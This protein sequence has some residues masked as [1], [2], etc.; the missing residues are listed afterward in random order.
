MINPT[1]RDLRAV[2]SFNLIQ[3]YPIRDSNT[4]RYYTNYRNPYNTNS[5]VHNQNGKRRL[6]KYFNLVITGYEYIK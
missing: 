3:I 2:T 5:I 6:I 1:L 4:V